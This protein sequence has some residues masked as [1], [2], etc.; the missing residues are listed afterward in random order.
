MNNYLLAVE[1]GKEFSN[2]A[3]NVSDPKNIANI[4][5]AL[6]TGSISL[7]GIGMIVLIIFGGIGMISGAGNSDPK[8]IDAGK[9]A[10]TSGLIGFIVVFAAYWIVKLIET[11]TGLDLIGGIA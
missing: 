5:S 4:V 6:V 7:A 10:A 3:S 9:K 8:A 11:L 1:I 2:N